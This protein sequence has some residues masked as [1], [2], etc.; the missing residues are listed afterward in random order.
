MGAGSTFRTETAR[1]SVPDL[2]TQ[3]WA[4]PFKRTRVVALLTWL[5]I[6][7][8]GAEPTPAE[9]EA[10]PSEASATEEAT[11]T[12]TPEPTVTPALTPTTTPLPTPAE[13]TAPQ[14]LT[15]PPPPPSV[16]YDNCTEARDAGAAP[17]RAGDPGYGPHLDRDGD[18][19]GCETD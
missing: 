12:P 11:A 18:G 19:V 7:C 3:G 2:R 14:G 17:V 13:T 10:T 6:G 16:H 8:G 5:L 9:T 4:V 1:G 15:A